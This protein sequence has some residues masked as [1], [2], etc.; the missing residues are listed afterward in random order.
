MR[1][2]STRVFG[3][4]T[5]YRAQIL[6]RPLARAS[7]TH[8]HLAW[9]LALR[10]RLLRRILSPG[11]RWENM[12][13]ARPAR[14]WIS[15]P[16]TLL[17][18]VDPTRPSDRVSIRERSVLH[19]GES[20]HLLNAVS[21]TSSRATG[22]GSFVQFAALPQWK[23]HTSY[24]AALS[25]AIAKRN[26]TLGGLET[27]PRHEHSQGARGSGLSPLHLVLA[28]HS[29]GLCRNAAGSTP[30]DAVVGRI[31]QRHRRVEEPALPWSL[32]SA[33]KKRTPGLALVEPL[34][35]AEKLGPRVRRQSDGRF[36]SAVTRIDPTAQAE[37]AV[38]V[39]RI[40]DA[41]LMQLDRRLV[42]A[43][44]RMGRI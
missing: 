41:V 14:H 11:M 37:S 42:A 13:L 27:I 29:L 44:E 21:V 8:P 28:N 23:R 30:G 9:T 26:R 3:R 10:A 33:E 34:L 36:A 18:R 25:G 35:A 32:T 16:H 4:R 39:E 12:I 43:R 31:V 6:R 19:L 17:L 20:R 7:R 40:T 38:N 2:I 22:A 15:W 5:P 24:E 1:V